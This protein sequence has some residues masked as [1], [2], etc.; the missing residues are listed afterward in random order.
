[1]LCLLILGTVGAFALGDAYVDAGLPAPT[2]TSDKEDY[3]P[4]DTAHITGTGWKLDQK[5][6]V[7]FKEEPDYPDFHIYNV[8]VNE[9]GTWKIDYPIEERHLGV[10]FTAVAVGEQTGFSATHIF[11]DAP[12]ITNLTYGTQSCFNPT[13][14]TIT[15]PV[16]VTGSKANANSS[17][18][19]ANL[20]V[21]QGLPSGVT[22]SFSPSTLTFNSTN[23]T[24]LTSTLTLT[25]PSGSSFTDF[26]VRVRAYAIGSCT[27]NGG[28]NFQRTS[29][30]T[31]KIAPS[32]TACPANITTGTATGVCNAQV[33]YSATASGT[34]APTYTYAFS[35][36]TTG[37]GNG[38]GSGSTFNR[39]TT[40]VIV[41]A[42][43]SC[44]ST[45]CTF[46]VT[47]EDRENPTIAAPA[48]VIVGADAG[49]CSATNIALG[50][51]TTR[52][53]CSVA[54]VSNNAPTTFPIGTTTVTY[55]VTD[56]A[57]RTAT[58]NQTVTVEDR[59]NPIV[60]AA[61]DQTSGTDEGTCTATIA[62]PDATFTDNCTGAQLRW[63]M[64]GAT[65]GNG[66][67]QVGTYTFNQGE[68]TITYTATDAAGNS[69]TDQ[70]LVT[71]TD[72]EAPVLTAPA[73][74]QV[75]ANAQC[76]ATGV[77]LGTATTTDNC[78]ANV[79]VTNN[80]PTT[81]PLGETTVT[82]T[83][84]DAAGNTATATQTV[85]V[86]D[87]TAP[88]LI[89]AAN[90]NVLIGEA[91]TV[92]IPDVRGKATDNCSGGI[93]ITQ[94]PAAGSKVATTDGQTIPVLV[95]ALDA[96]GNQSEATV[97]LTAQDETAPVLACPSNQIKTNNPGTCSYTTVGT[98]FDPISSDNCGVVSRTNDY[99]NSA[100]LAGATFT[101]TTTVTWTATDAAGNVSTCSFEIKVDNAAPVLS[102]LTGPTVPVAVGT[103]VS[104]SATS[105]D[106]NLA[107]GTFTFSSDGVTYSNPQPA[108]IT[109][110]KV[111]GTFT[112]PTGVYKVKLLVTD[113]CGLTAEVELGGFVVVYDPNGGF[114]TGGGWIYSSPGSL[115]SK[116]LA[117]GTANFGFNA[118]YKTGKNNVAEVDGST[119]FQFQE[120]D[121]H[122]KSSQHDAMSLV[123]SGRKATYR[124]TG[125]VNGS[126]VYNFMVTVI[127]GN[128]TGGDGFD[129]FRIKIWGA[130]SSTNVVYDNEL[131]EVENADATTKIG[132]GSIVIHKPAQTSSK[133]SSAVAVTELPVS[134]EAKLTSYPNPLTDEATVEF[135]VDQEEE[136]SLD[137]Y[138][139]KGALVKNLR[140]GKAMAGETVQAKWDART[141]NVGVYIIRL[142][143]SN[144]VKTVRVVR[145]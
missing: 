7:E 129:Y 13:T 4:G 94:S 23:E 79:T 109:N 68:T 62:I 111:S 131:G 135:S 18:I 49:S 44:G 96:A 144:K 117:H 58:A 20:C 26:D 75:A 115:P 142:S 3:Y 108:T 39:G 121:F 87:E 59:E 60:T 67:G 127:D 6:R 93:Q 54:N 57:G 55:T 86:V 99:N 95:T 81:F 41:T 12:R 84:V 76:Q 128:L 123:I 110:G 33:N 34:P 97:T 139:M 2:F 90:Q 78:S 8:T 48:N 36:A 104:F 114:V 71:V 10:K 141:T 28:D 113:A 21:N 9:D 35:G 80:A 25:F 31:Y 65:T 133:S 16:N 66:Q 38:T 63:A 46:T 19:T 14:N 42:T 140:K 132:S 11:T 92:T 43:N 51:P 103:P 17:N 27:G 85:T 56:G 1:M 72:D 120:G 134:T 116:P 91:C 32:F 29:T 145:R 77:T 105:T 137:I 37:T 125:T 70:L 83:A 130:G 52:D 119:N 22:A 89:A 24:T 82:Y 45:T 112:L 74:V 30:I 40:N 100:T 118:K 15:I 122:F 107:S 88:V 106:N 69:S 64:K 50:T 138:D 61:T 124:G 47:V 126:G 98:E 136:Y 101:G 53:N 102:P 143:T 5:L 73:A